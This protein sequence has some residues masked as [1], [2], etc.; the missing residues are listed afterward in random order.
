MHVAGGGERVDDEAGQD[1]RA[2]RVEP[3]LERGHDAEVAAA[4]PEPPEEV[5]LVLL[6]RVEELAVGR[7]DVGGERGCRRSARACA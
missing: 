6:A 2:H 1:L 3:E 4:A 7:H 5:G